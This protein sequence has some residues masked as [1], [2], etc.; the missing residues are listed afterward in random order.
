MPTVPNE[1]AWGNAVVTSLPYTL[2]NSGASNEFIS[3]NFSTTSGNAAYDTTTPR[4]GSINGPLRVGIFAG[5]SGNTGR[6]TSGA[7]YYGIMEMSGNLLEHFVTVGNPT[8]RLFTGNHGNGILT[9]SGNADV[10]GW[11]GVTSLGAGFRGGYWYFYAWYLR[12]SERVSAAG[13]DAVHYNSDG[14]RGGRTA[15]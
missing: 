3:G 13:T 12:I 14:G 9:T 1:C 15:P 10:N 4:F 7:T 5:T 11:P 8:G 6:I 2:G